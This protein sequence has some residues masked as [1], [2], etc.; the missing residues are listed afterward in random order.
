MSLRAAR[1]V[2][3]QVAEEVEEIWRGSKQGLLEL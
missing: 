2:K 3:S 1:A